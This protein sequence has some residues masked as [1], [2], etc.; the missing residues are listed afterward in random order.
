MLATGYWL[1]STSLPS[2]F[3]LHPSSLPF[4][5]SFVDELDDGDER[6]C[7]RGVVDAD[8]GGRGVVPFDL[9]AALEC[10]RLDGLLQLRE[11][12]V[13]RLDDVAARRSRLDARP[14]FRRR[15]PAVLVAALACLDER[16]PDGHAFE[17]AA[18]DDDVEVLDGRVG[19]EL[20][21]VTRVSRVGLA[22]VRV[23]GVRAGVELRVREEHGSV[24]VVLGVEDVDI[25]FGVRL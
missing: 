22:D 18:R 15:L 16:A 7:V 13:L 19:V 20:E 1:L 4:A 10:D 8:D 2:S 12:R 5:L 3:R 25:A 9:D 11:L 6:V 21:G 14:L 23:R 24:A 17:R